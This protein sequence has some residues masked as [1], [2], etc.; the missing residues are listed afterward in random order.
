MARTS[1]VFSLGRRPT[2]KEE[3]KKEEAKEDAGNVNGTVPETEDRPATPVEQRA[4]T[5]E[6]APSPYEESQPAETGTGFAVQPPRDDDVGT[7]S[8][9]AT[10][11]TVASQESPKSQ[12]KLKSWFK[13]KVNRRASKQ[14]MAEEPPAETQD[15]ETNSRADVTTPVDSSLAAPL[16][17]H[18]VTEQD[19]ASSVRSGDHD[20]IRQW[21]TS[22]AGSAQQDKTP[23]NR[24]SR[25]RM[26]L[27]GMITR[28]NPSEVS[29]SPLSSPTTPTAAPSGNVGTAALARPDA[30]RLNTMERV[31]LRDSFT[32]G[33]L[34]PPPNL[35][36]APKR[37]SVGSS[38]RD[39][40]FSEDI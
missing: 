18:P 38:A 15:R 35:F 26:S 8:R 3:P 2:V 39:S 23:D 6:T 37:G 20:P 27:K 24:R 10:D 14:P 13:S 33:S 29:E 5:Q 9:T 22:T 19:I 31:E 30:A 25:L 1:R 11:P 28:K 12:S 4:E 21:S 36:T 32:E 34:P 7:V 16:S 17:S 40:K